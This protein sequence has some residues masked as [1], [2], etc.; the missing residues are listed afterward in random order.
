MD[1]PPLGLATIALH[2]G[3]A[4]DPFTGAA[5]VPIYQ[6]SSFVFKS[7][8]HARDLFAL[9]EPG[10][11][12]SRIMN[13][14]TDALEKRLAALHGGAGALATSSGQA[15][16]FLAIL[17]IT[18]AGKN[19]VSGSNLYGGTRTLLGTTLARMGIETRFVDSSDP[20]NFARAADDNTRLFFTE[21]L[22]N[23]RCNVDDLAAIARLAHDR[24]LPF[25]VDNTVSPPP[26]GN[27]F[28]HGADILVYSLTKMLGGHGNSIGGAVVD[29]GRFDW[30][31][32]GRYPEMTA[33]D[34][35]SPQTYR[36]SLP[37]HTGAPCPVYILKLRTGLMRDLGPCLAPM[38]AF[39][40]LQ[41]LETLPFRGRIHCA[42]ARKVAEFLANHPAVTWVNYAG[43]PGHPDY[44]R[45]QRYFPLGPGAVF[46]FGI[47]GG[48]AAGEKFIAHVKLCL[49]LANILDART[50]VI[51]PAST[52]HGQL[53][54]AEM[55]AAGV[56]P[57]MIRLSVGLEE[58][59]DIIADLE[60]AL[61]A[62][63]AA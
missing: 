17:A 29:S 1:Y 5:Q 25:M 40:I 45:A 35:A 52:T 47:K 36:P 41:G 51:H 24:G 31:T 55:A 60:Q 46:G 10:Y 61:D 14:T 13:P 16:T 42:N 54:E 27:P 58:A 8:A 44:Q 28:D 7:V 18:R 37:D 3:Q 2:A 22:G 43:L 30:T 4:P 53:G 34:P 32:G 62:S 38:N 49:H 39:L 59:E 50:L 19:L 21:S 20:N 15:A 26:V 57:D 63:Q 6:T 11:I 9:G 33:P 56:T 48:Q 12:Y 23:P